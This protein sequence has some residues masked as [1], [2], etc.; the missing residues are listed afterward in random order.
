MPEEPFEER[1][2]PAT[3]KK[4]QEVRDKGQVAKSVELNSAGIFF[5]GIITIY[6]VSGPTM[7]D[8]CGLIRD[9]LSSAGG[10]SSSRSNAP[11]VFIEM[12][13]RGITIVAPILAILF[14]VALS[15]NFL[16]VGVK[17]TTPPLQPNLNP[18]DPINGIKRIFFS[19]RTIME[20]FK[21]IFKLALIGYIIYSTLYAEK[22]RLLVLTDQSIIGIFTTLWTIILKIGLKAGVFLVVLAAL[23]YAFQKWDFEKK[24]RM[25]KKEVQDELKHQE[26]NPKVKAKIRS[27][28]IKMARSRM[29]SRVKE[30]DVVVTNPVSI[31]IALK[32]DPEKMV[33]PV[34]VA[35]GKKRLARKIVEIAKDHQVPVMENVTL[36]QALYRTTEVGAQVAL[37]L[38]KAVAEVLAFVYKLKG[39]KLF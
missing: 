6:V 36:A 20:L 9:G 33:A 34:V 22:D 38:Y 12:V 5:L 35:K 1:T 29:L 17:V 4:R 28:Q 26:G 25:T 24:I 23:D 10:F 27:L 7:N 13:S 37:E 2:E 15:A 32:Y 31:A 30:A 16:Q 11:Y 8:L 21:G 14:I 3:T 19:P 39:K 18:L